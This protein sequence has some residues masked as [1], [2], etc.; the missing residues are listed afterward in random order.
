MGTPRHQAQPKAPWLAAESKVHSQKERFKTRKK[1]QCPR[2]PRAAVPAPTQGLETSNFTCRRSSPN[3][4]AA[5][6]TSP[7]MTPRWGGT[8]NRHHSMISDETCLDN[9]TPPVFSQTLCPQLE[10]E[11]PPEHQIPA[12]CHLKIPGTEVQNQVPT[13][14]LQGKRCLILCG[15]QARVGYRQG[16]RSCRSYRIQQDHEVTGPVP[17][18]SNSS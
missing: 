7:E 16:K 14:A 4:R 5:S 6:R 10:G 2:L 17:K 18:R 13:G 11:T 3:R 15:G 9:A 8:D 1:N 12:S